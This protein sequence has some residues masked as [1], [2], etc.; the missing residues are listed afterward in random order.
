[1]T[2]AAGEKRQVLDKG[3]PKDL[4]DFSMETFKAQREEHDRVK[5]KKCQPSILY[6]AK[7]S[8]TN[9]E[10]KEINNTKPVLREMPK[11]I[12]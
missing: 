11:G 6:P 7:L 12:L 2:K 8:F 5:E 9:G 1:M 4:V 3:T 10:I